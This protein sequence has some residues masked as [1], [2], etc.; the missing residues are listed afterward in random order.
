MGLD[1][2]VDESL[3]QLG[4]QHLRS[5]ASIV[6]ASFVLAR[7]KVML[8]HKVLV[9]VIQ[10]GLSFLFKLLRMQIVDLLFH[11][12]LFILESVLSEIADEL[13]VVLRLTVVPVGLECSSVV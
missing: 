4:A 11:F 10:D 5:I 12:A 1:V 2:E 9:P 3:A 13:V 7:L 6:G 8:L